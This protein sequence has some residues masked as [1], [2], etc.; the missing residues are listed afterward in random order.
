MNLKKAIEERDQKKELYLIA[1]RE[2][3]ARISSELH[4]GEGG[5]PCRV[6]YKLADQILRQEMPVI[7][8]G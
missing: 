1:E 4:G 7:S 2:R 8:Q 3:I 5:T 6:C